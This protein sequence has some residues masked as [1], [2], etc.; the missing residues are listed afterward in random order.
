MA[1]RIVGLDLGAYSVKLLRL[2][3]GKQHPRFEV[4][5]AWEEVL[6]DEEPEGP[7]L[8]ERQ[9]QTLASLLQN[10]PLEAETYAIGLPAIDGNMLTMAVP[11]SE[12]RKIEAVLP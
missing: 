9:R 1:R 5:E 4:L 6:P 12:T 11:F 8:L 7:D 2:E 3:V 10:N